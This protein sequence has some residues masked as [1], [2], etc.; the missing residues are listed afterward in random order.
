MHI[1]KFKRR[2]KKKGTTPTQHRQK[3]DKT[4]K[5][6]QIFQTGLTFEEKNNLQA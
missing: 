2:Y 6:K 3:Y 4:K 5:T 1:V